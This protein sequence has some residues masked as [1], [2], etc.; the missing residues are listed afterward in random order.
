M[1]SAVFVSKS[2]CTLLSNNLLTVEVLNPSVDQDKLPANMV[3]FDGRPFSDT[4]HPYFPNPLQGRVVINDDA[5]EYNCK[6]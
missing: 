1:F 6:K 5:G 3:A 4:I 2:I